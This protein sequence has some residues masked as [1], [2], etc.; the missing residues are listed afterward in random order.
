MDIRS[1]PVE[2]LAFIDIRATVK[3]EGVRGSNRSRSLITSLASAIE[4]VGNSSLR[5]GRM[6][7]QARI[8]VYRS[9]LVDIDAATESGITSKR[10]SPR[11]T[12]VASADT[13]I[14]VGCGTN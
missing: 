7:I 8:G 1:T 14:H 2:L 12:R 9:T 6:N 3:R 13:L 4:S 5:T 10:S 11:K